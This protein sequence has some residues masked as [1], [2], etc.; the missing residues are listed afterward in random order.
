VAAS[1][2]GPGSD[3]SAEQARK[4]AAANAELARE[5]DGL[6]L[7]LVR[8]ASAA[9]EA[10]EARDAAERELR[11]GRD[12]I[13]ALEAETA[14][15]G[16]AAEAARRPGG[17]GHDDGGAAALAREI[18]ALQAGLAEGMAA[19]GD[20]EQA[21]GAAGAANGGPVAEG[22]GPAAVAEGAEL[23]VLHS[24]LQ[25]YRRRAARLRDELEGVRRRW[26]TLSPSEI[27]GYLE[28]LGEDL[29]EMEK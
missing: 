5:R 18:D 9:A 13:A 19:L 12:R 15:L 20:L 25:S 10:A 7:E 27:S 28:E 17:N 26:E 21:L 29:A 4:L 8:V 2:P 3:A 6:R 1:A 24:T 23:A 14:R 22:P 16:T 11:G